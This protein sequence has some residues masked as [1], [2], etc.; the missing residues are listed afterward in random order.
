M[1]NFSIL[2]IAECRLVFPNKRPVAGSNAPPPQFAPP[3]TPGRTT[4]P[5]IDGGVYSAARRYFFDSPNARSFNC[6]VASNASSRVT[7]CD[8]NAGGLVGKG[9]VGHD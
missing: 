7:P 2:K 1:S 8:S 5:C 4:V 3:I 9:C 6:G